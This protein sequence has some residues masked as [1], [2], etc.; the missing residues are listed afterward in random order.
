MGPS[1]AGSSC[2]LFPRSITV[3]RVSCG[4]MISENTKY[5]GLKKVSLEV[6]EQRVWSV[7]TISSGRHVGGLRRC[8][9]IKARVQV[10]MRPA[11]CH[12]YAS[13]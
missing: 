4:R 13:F 9:G 2:V 1:R 6:R 11:S 5:F 3:F 8:I 12:K 7:A 10:G